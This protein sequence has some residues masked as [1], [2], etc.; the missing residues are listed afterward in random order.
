MDMKVEML[1]TRLYQQLTWK[2]IPYLRCQKEEGSDN[3]DIKVV[4]RN[5]FAV[6]LKR[7]SQ[8][9]CCKQLTQ[10][11]QR[12][13]TNTRQETSQGEQCKTSQLP[14]KATLSRSTSELVDTMS[15]DAEESACRV[16]AKK[17]ELAPGADNCLNQAVARKTKGLLVREKKKKNAR[18]GKTWRESE[19]DNP[20]KSQ[21]QHQ[22]DGKE[23]AA[24]VTEPQTEVLH[25]D[26]LP[27]TAQFKTLHSPAGHTSDTH[28]D[29]LCEETIV[30]KRKKK[31]K[32][33][34]RSRSQEEV[35]GMNVT[36]GPLN[37]DSMLR[38]EEGDTS[39]LKEKKRKKRE[40]AAENVNNLEFDL[41]VEDSV[42]SLSTEHGGK[43][44][45]KKSKR[46]ENE[47]EQ[48]QSS[49]VSEP[50]ND[51]AEI[52]KKHKKRRKEEGIVVAEEGN[53]LAASEQTLESSFV[54][55]KKHK[56]KKHSSSKE[57]S[58]HGRS[59][60]VECVDGSSVNDAVETVETSPKKTK[61][62]KKKTLI[63]GVDNS[64]DSEENKKFLNE[65]DIL[66]TVE[67]LAD[68]N[69]E[70][71]VRKKKKKK[72]SEDNMVQSGDS[73]SVQEK[74]SSVLCAD[75]ESSPSLKAYVWG[76]EKP[77]VS[78][79][80]LE[81]ESEE[82]S[83]N[84]EISNN[85][86]RER[87]EENVESAEWCGKKIITRTKKKNQ[88]QG[89]RGP[90]VES[91]TQGGKRTRAGNEAELMTP[92]E[93]FESAAD[94]GLSSTDGAVVLRKKRKLEDAAC[95]VMHESPTAET[96]E[97]GSTPSETPIHIREKK[98]KERVKHTDN[99]S[100]EVNSLTESAY[101]EPKVDNKK[102]KERTT[103]SAEHNITP[104]S[105][106]L[107]GTSFLKPQMS[108]DRLMKHTK[109]KRKLH[110]PNED[111]LTDF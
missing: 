107:S 80:N 14:A 8:Q 42:S 26:D 86:D 56:K 66:K 83:G 71:R 4:E 76:A 13:A 70:V 78:A 32:D 46:R 55:R 50:L 40:A 104:S 2:R 62:K 103:Q 52:Q 41:R 72:R 30:K 23:A 109:V 15:C 3:E 84:L 68:Q 33:K 37:E 93:S 79:G 110:N 95:R 35:Q 108:S 82:V 74:S 102:E 77:G 27:Q 99:L 10:K 11:K 51:N 61:K 53:C 20:Q 90:H 88:T 94:A 25:I 59:S 38:Q 65:D 43:K 75:P 101:L 60:P 97:T 9:T 111:F 64:F 47:E 21:L 73:M 54:K 58:Q 67:G 12:K 39:D 45:K 22:E 31:K 29:L 87:K 18:E 81:A 89:V 17:D 57:A 24:T 36:E 6:P 91:Q 92:V 44:K 7:K 98:K 105:P 85:E 100:F 19:V 96:E 1:W 49:A 48:Q 34:D 28:T 69:A 5:V 16:K 63:E 106:I